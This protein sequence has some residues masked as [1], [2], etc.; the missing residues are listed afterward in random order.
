[1]KTLSFNRSFAGPMVVLAVML[2]ALGIVSSEAFQTNPSVL[3]VAITVDLTLIS[4]L[5]YLLLVRKTN[6]P[7]ISVVPVFVL[8]LIISGL[9][10]PSQHHATLDFIESWVL[11]I[12][13]LTAISIIFWKFVKLRKTFKAR[14]A[15]HPD[16]FEAMKE[17]A[18]QVIPGKVSVFL[19]TELSTFYYGLFCWR[20]PPLAPLEFTYHKKS[21]SVALLYTVMLVAMA[22]TVILHLLIERW[23]ETV[24][25]ILTV[26]SIYTVFQVLGIV[27]SMNKRPIKMADGQI[28][29]RYGMLSE[30]NLPFNQ[31]ASI[32][33]STVDREWDKEVRKLTPFGDLESHNVIL[34][35]KEPQRISGMYGFKKSFR[36]LAFHVDQPHDFVAEVERAIKL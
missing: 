6:I 2:V 28:K 19:A 25:W 22:E 5:L 12:V 11:P 20:K 14:S 27:R 18:K 30:V 17:A 8:G 35:V 32:E 26:I 36:E 10:L 15:Q 4:P 7:S 21:G 3:A 34:K 13:E 9:L 31:I 29:L 23:S 24:A 16:F 33:A 1:M